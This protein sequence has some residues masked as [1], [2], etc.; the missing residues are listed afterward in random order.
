MLDTTSDYMAQSER[1]NTQNVQDEH[2]G[3][4][5]E[6]LRSGLHSSPFKY[7]PVELIQQIAKHLSVVS[8][9]CLTLSS[10]SMAV[11]VGKFKSALDYL[12]THETIYTLKLWSNWQL[13]TAFKA[14]RLGKDFNT[15]E[16]IGY[17]YTD[18][19]H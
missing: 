6:I 16:T 10:Y 17:F 13:L 2:R 5:N 15:S 1:F 11:L 8:E 7:L 18:L 9:I 12:L 19:T 14:H 4:G 3:P